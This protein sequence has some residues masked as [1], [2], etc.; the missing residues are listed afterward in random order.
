MAPQVV[1]KMSLEAT[2]ILWR[3]QQASVEMQ[4][5]IDVQVTN[6][7]PVTLGDRK[8]RTSDKDRTVLF[9]GRRRRLWKRVG[10]KSL[11]NSVVFVSH[12]LLF[13]RVFSRNLIEHKVQEIRLPMLGNPFVNH[14]I[15]TL[16]GIE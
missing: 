3:Q 10:G 7:F 11:L 1:I 8:V 4:P 13:C 6:Q 5:M 14:L 15:K 9:P 16:D 2:F 12:N